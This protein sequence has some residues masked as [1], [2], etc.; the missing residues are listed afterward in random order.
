MIELPRIPMIKSGLTQQTS[1]T[2]LLNNLLGVLIVEYDLAF[3][4]FHVEMLIF[5]TY[6]DVWIVKICADWNQ[7]RFPLFSK[8]KIV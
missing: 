3:D 2:L 7:L 6:F 8:T 1:H 4:V 5:L